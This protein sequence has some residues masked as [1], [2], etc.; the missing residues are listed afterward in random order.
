MLASS[1]KTEWSSRPA[2]RA[3]RAKSITNVKAYDLVSVAMPNWYS[4]L[5]LSG[6]Y[7]SFSFSLPSALLDSRNSRSCG[8][9]SRRRTHCS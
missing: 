8:A 4:S 2:R 1:Y 6:G 9:V 5:K 7:F 3:I